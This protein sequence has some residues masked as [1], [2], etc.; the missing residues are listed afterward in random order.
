MKIKF[1]KHICQETLTWPMTSIKQT[2]HFVL[3]IITIFPCLNNNNSSPLCK[4]ITFQYHIIPVYCQKSVKE[5]GGMSNQYSLFHV[6]C[7]L[8]KH[9]SL[10]IYSISVEKPLKR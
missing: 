1:L 9:V 6:T 5:I 10:L 2:T 7:F 3:D 4:N 8:R